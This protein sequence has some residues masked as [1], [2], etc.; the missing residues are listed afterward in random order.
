M[1][2]TAD[3]DVIIYHDEQ[4][5]IQ[6]MEKRPAGKGETKLKRID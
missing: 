4:M 2:M 3:K 6:M 1:N 5:I